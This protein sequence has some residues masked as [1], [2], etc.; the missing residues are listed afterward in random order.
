MIC[1]RKNSKTL[2][3]DL[4]N[5]EIEL[6]FLFG[7]KRSRSGAEPLGNFIQVDSDIRRFWSCDRILRRRDD[8]SVQLRS[9]IRSCDSF[10]TF[11]LRGGCVGVFRELRRVFG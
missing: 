11:S 2:F 5:L 3:A 4:Q 1:V 8:S 6:E 10:G 9:C 7:F